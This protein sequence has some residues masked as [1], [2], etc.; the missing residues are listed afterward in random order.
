MASLVNRG[1]TQV[2]VDSAGNYVGVVFDGTVYRLQTETAIADA[3]LGTLAQ[4]VQSGNRKALSV[5][6]PELL[7]EIRSLAR[8]VDKVLAHLAQ[9]NDE[10]DPL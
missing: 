5:E 9:I 3:E 1:P 8:K 10:E 7:N 6:Y 2:L 4:V